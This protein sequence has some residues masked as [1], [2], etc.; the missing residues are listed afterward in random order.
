MQDKPINQWTRPE[1][2]RYFEDVGNGH[3]SAVNLRRA[4]ERTLS[5]GV[6]TRAL[7]RD[8]PKFLAVVERQLTVIGDMIER[9]PPMITAA[10]ESLA[11]G[12]RSAE[13]ELR[14]VKDELQACHDLLHEALALASQPPRPFDPERARAAQ[15]AY[16]R[17]ETKP[18]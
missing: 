12:L 4:L 5:G 1:I 18:F 16:E 3:R 2:E 6:E 14:S 10:P 17:G 9:L 15:E 7:A 13:S 11:S 8:F